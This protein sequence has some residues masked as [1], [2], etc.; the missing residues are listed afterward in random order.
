MKNYI[1]V[2]A[3]VACLLTAS[4]NAQEATWNDAQKEV[5]GLV[6][7]SWMDDVAENGKWPAEYIHDSYVSWGD[8]SAAPRYNN[9]G[10]RHFV[11]YRFIVFIAKPTPSNHCILVSGCCTAV[12]P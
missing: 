11:H 10:R 2:G 9:C 5:W 6:Q 4:V 1:W 3:I 12:A 7:Q 8:S